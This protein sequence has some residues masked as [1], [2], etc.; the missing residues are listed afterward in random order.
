MNKIYLLDRRTN[1]SNPWT[2]HI[3]H[4]TP[5]LALQQGMKI[6]F[7]PPSRDLDQYHQTTRQMNDN[8]NH[9][10]EKNENIYMNISN[11]PKKT[12]W[13]LKLTDSKTI[14]SFHILWLASLNVTKDLST[15]NFT[16]SLENNEIL[17]NGPS[18]SLSLYIWLFLYV[19]LNTVLLH[20]N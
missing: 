8:L 6:P 12:L 15:R 3:H 13:I 7:Y 10:P 11:F 9:K 18:F 16:G 5:W 17:K 2:L 20:Q 14:L 1:I 4:L 19:A